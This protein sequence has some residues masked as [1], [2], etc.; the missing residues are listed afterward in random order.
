MNQN[1]TLVTDTLPARF[2]AVNQAR[3]VREEI[4]ADTAGGGYD[5]VHQGI[6]SLFRV[7]KS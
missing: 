6:T 5:C 4:A 3:S 7:L 2:L 1:G